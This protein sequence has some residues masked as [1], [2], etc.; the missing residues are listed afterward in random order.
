MNPWRYLDSGPATGMRNMEIDERL[1]ADAAADNGLLPVLRFY[2]WEPPAVS[3]GRF[4]DEAS[5]VRAASCDRLGID[6]VR[7]ITGGRAVLHH[8]E[9]TYSIVSARSNEQFPDDVLGTYK[10]IA[11]GLLMGLRNLGISAEM[12]TRPKWQEPPKAGR[13]DAACF[14]SPSWY[15][16][17]AGGR[18]I[19][20][21]AQRR[22][23]GAFLQHGS[24]LIGY[25]PVLEAAV[26]PGGGRQDAV[27]SIEGELGR[28]IG[29]DA[30]KEAFLQ[31]FR[32][33]LRMDLQRP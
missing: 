1:L 28:T 25:D 24:I 20:G 9:L 3:L 18:K 11:A 5:A 4:Q 19:I 13:V 32:M 7:R 16:L 6:I 12:V 2:E 29:I 21:S 22:L 17:V 33:V 27:T 10:T 26:I 8:R 15:E 23:P 14:A 30:V 31:G